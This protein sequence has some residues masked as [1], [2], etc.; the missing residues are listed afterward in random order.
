MKSVTEYRTHRKKRRHNGAS[1][2][3]FAGWSV[4]KRRVS[5]HSLAY[6][7]TL[8]NANRPKGEE[9]AEAPTEKFKEDEDWDGA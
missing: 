2:N 4:K 5:G 9:Q 8:A 7:H 6:I 1:P 3:F